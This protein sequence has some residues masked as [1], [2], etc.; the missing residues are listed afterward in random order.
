MSIQ[1]LKL[2]YRPADVA[3]AFGSEELYRRAVEAGLLKPK[4]Q[5]RKLVIYNAADVIKCWS[6][7]MD[8]GIPPPRARKTPR[9]KKA[10]GNGMK[11][12]DHVE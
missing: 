1:A 10:D 12:A 11:G 3:E 6:T 9:K 8:G 7:M 4:I 2:G 5:E